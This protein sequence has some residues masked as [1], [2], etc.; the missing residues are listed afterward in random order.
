[1]M[2]AERLGNHGSLSREVFRVTFGVIRCVC[3]ADE[4]L[5]G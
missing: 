2:R 1:M 3:G 5:V 4:K